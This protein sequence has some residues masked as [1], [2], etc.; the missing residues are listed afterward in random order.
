MRLL[1]DVLRNREMGI[2]LLL[3]L[4]A[5]LFAG[6]FAIDTSDEFDDDG[7]DQPD[8]STSL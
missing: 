4:L 2:E 7:M 8:D 3:A 6:L 1:L 5:S